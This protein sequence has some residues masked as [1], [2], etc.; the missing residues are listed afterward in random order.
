MSHILVCAVPNPGHVGPMLSVAVHLKK[1]G[2]DVTFTTSEHFSNRVESAGIS[3]VPF[4]GKAN[5]DYRSFNS[6]K[7]HDDV[8]DQKLHLL[9]TYFADTNPR[10]A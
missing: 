5:Y 10:S 7:E 6:S 1:I 9:E 3:F 8:A 2:H 4:T